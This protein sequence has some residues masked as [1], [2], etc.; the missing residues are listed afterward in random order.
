[1]RIFPIL[2]CMAGEKFKIYKSSAGSGKTFTLVKEY[3]GIALRE[4][5]RYKNILALTFT[6]KAAGEMK[7]RILSELALLARGKDSPMRQVLIDEFDLPPAD[8]ADAATAVLGNILHDYANFAVRTIDSFTH[9]LIRSFAKDLELPG[10]FE[11]EMDTKL[12]LQR[13]V[14]QLMDS[15]G[16]DDYV[17]E[18]LVRF[19]EEK[20]RDRSG[21][22]IEADLKEVG[23]E[24]FK[25]NSKPFLGA[26]RDFD[27][28]LF[29]EFIALL[30]QQK[31]AFP[32][33]IQGLARTA[34]QVVKQHGLHARD[35]N[36]STNSVVGKLDKLC[37]EMKPAEIN[38]LV[39]SKVF[40]E[41]AEDD[42]WLKKGEQNPR[43]D[44]ALDA[45]LRAQVVAIWDYFQ[46]E[47][48][49]FLTAWHAFQ[50]VHSLAVMQQIEDLIEHYKAQ[51]NLVHISD[52]QPKIE[53][54]M[55]EEAPDY[56]YW[57]LGERY[58]HYML[59]EFQDTSLLQWLNLRPLVDNL[60]AGGAGQNGSLLIVG[61]S[62]QAI[63]RWRG[64]ETSLMELMV[65]HDLG[66]TP[67][68][69][70]RNY[71]SK[72]YV[73][74][75]N[76]RFFEEAVS[77]VAAEQPEIGLIYEGMAQLVRSGNETQGF[78][79]VEL[80]NTDD[81]PYA[82][83]AYMRTV[84]L[85]QSLLEQ[86]FQLRDIAILVRT[87]GE[88]SDIAEVL[89]QAGIKVISAES[90]LLSKSPVVNFLVS[91][92]K[93]LFDPVDGIAR[94]EVLHYFFHYLHHDTAWDVDPDR[95]IREL[96][97]DEHPVT[98]MLEVLPAEFRRLSYRTDRLS[99]YELAEETVRIFGLQESA[100]AFVQH[101]LDVVLE[102]AERKKP[103]LGAFLEYWEEKKEGFSLIVPDGE[104][105]VE[106][107]TIHKS[108]G[109]EFPVV[110]IPKADWSTLPKTGS[111]IWAESGELF[112]DY[113]SA[114][115]IK[116]QAG[117][118]DS[119]FG[120][121][122]QEEV[123]KT[124][125][126][127]MNL[128][129]VAFTRPRERLYVLAPDKSKSAKK[130]KAPEEIKNVGALIRR[131]LEAEGFQAMDSTLYETG[132]PFPPAARTADVQQVAVP[133][134]ISTP[135]RDRIRIDR[136][137]RK[138][139]ETGEGEQ[140]LQAGPLLAQ[141]FRSLHDSSGLALALDRLE[142][143]GLVQ[144]HGRAALETKAN[145]ILR[146]PTLAAFFA[147]GQVVRLGMKFL[148]GQDEA[149]AVDRVVV[150]ETTTKL[151]VIIDSSREKAD[152]KAI[153]SCVAFLAEQEAQSVEAWMLSLPAGK[154]ERVGG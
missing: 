137:F 84:E 101:F 143:M 66:V 114:H 28:A 139:W 41:A 96:L 86:G 10:R 110:I 111:T 83:Q 132:F 87:K 131:V 116:P 133:R 98:A 26:I 18:I 24:L 151:L 129:Y 4:P 76:N 85:V 150:T 50:N 94:A 57:R 48:D 37:T 77:L 14:D 112:G 53:Q 130:S 146:E 117:I 122:Y 74:D 89:G 19:V 5:V 63:Y 71:R 9:K 23:Q 123:K 135:W 8:I 91:L 36:G 100:P 40:R 140:A 27:H 88:G 33:H 79:R 1:M 38:G 145:A 93:F 15:I 126:D 125:L 115:L 49:G 22:R 51:Y 107:M 103:D 20:L 152:R 109:L 3:L 42:R 21:W 80:I 127:N 106:I 67:L 121:T 64:G 46:A 149:L 134:L 61:D 78:V 144:A 13:T 16:R 138:F 6:N 153:G 25:E 32:D 2:P 113:P 102:F 17:T 11:I 12:I 147:V 58:Q 68:V 7:E 141:V 70:D 136:K 104:N 35:F 73:V 120:E 30:R 142:E 108:K 72:E 60:R 105:A 29:P 45:G 56:I 95:K 31:R 39:M 54:F 97:Q 119:A 154:V 65:P 44:A 81:G 59:D 99:L 118:E 75:F 62:K 34:M 69:L 128:L 52:F 92:F 124:L 55:R 82:E 90:I 148:L 43:V 47:Y